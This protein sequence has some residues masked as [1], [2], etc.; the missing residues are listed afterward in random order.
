MTTTLN[1]Y[2]PDQLAYFR[3]LSD[4]QLKEHFYTT[5]QVAKLLGTSPGRLAKRIEDNE[6]PSFGRF[7]ARNG[8][9]YS[10]TEVNNW[11]RRKTFLHEQTIP[12]KVYAEEYKFLSSICG[13]RW[14]FN[15][16]RSVYGISEDNLR[17]TL[18]QY[19]ITPPPR[20]DNP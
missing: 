14:A 5:K 18:R 15:R 1:H 16:L 10:K 8:Y 11:R 6:I 2:T 9:L 3:A 12:S 4:E 7:K 19:G 20:K 17:S 13:T